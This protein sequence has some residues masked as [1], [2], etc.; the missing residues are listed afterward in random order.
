MLEKNNA[1]LVCTPFCIFSYYTYTVLV[2]PF[3]LPPT[4]VS[5]TPPVLFVLL[6]SHAIQLYIYI[7][8]E[9]AG[10]PG[11]RYV[12]GRSIVLPEVY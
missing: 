5:C 9:A 7:T 12:P 10:V 2:L 8:T 1:N 3:G 11:V 6:L 4:Y